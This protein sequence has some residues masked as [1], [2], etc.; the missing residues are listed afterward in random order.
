MFW[1]QVQSANDTVVVK[2]VTNTNAPP[3]AQ[4]TQHAIVY[5]LLKREKRE[6]EALTRVPCSVV[7]PFT[8]AELNATVHASRV[9]VN[10]RT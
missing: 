4:K 5:L 9:D 10:S 8:V 6:G 1:A 3:A 7:R 2:P